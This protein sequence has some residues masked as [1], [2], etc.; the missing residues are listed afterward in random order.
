L[1][2]NGIKGQRGLSHGLE[3]FGRRHGE[4]FRD[5][6]GIDAARDGRENHILGGSAPSATVS[7][8]PESGLDAISAA[9]DCPEVPIPRL[10]VGRRIDATPAGNVGAD[11]RGVEVRE[12]SRD[13]RYPERP[14][15]AG[16]QARNLEH[17]GVDRLHSRYYTRVYIGGRTVTRDLRGGRMKWRGS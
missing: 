8:P 17:L 14:I 13:V 12:R 9:T 10:V 11:S 7:T 4:R 1:R 2:S 3:S 5:E 16:E 15:I 6:G